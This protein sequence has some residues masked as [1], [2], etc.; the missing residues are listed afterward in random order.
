MLRPGGTLHF[1]EHGLA[2]DASV[3]RWQRR[4]NRINQMIAGCRL[5]LDVAGLL[6]RSGLTGDRARAL[7]RAELAASGRLVLRGS[8]Q[9]L[10]ERPHGRPG[11][12]RR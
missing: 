1:V 5:D 7:L 6:A 11:R 9:R 10:S 8:R 3:V 2:P 12:L 4:G